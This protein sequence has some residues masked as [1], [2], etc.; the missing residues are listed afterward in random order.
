MGLLRPTGPFAS[1]A[2]W[3]LCLLAV[4]PA[5][6]AA[7]GPGFDERV[8]AQRAIEE[9]YWRHRSWPQANALPKP[10]P[11]ALV[12]EEALRT[13]VEDYLRKSSALERFW[14]RPL[15][16][17]RLQAELD[18]MSRSTRAPQVLRELYAALDD[19]ARLIAETLGRQTLVE[20]LI[21]QEYDRD[22]RLHG[23]I[24]KRARQALEGAR[25]ASEM[26]ILGGEYATTTYALRPAG[27]DPAGPDTAEVIALESAEWS[28]WSTQVAAWFGA[29]TLEAAPLGQPSALVEES[30]RFFAAALLSRSHGLA[31]VAT[32]TWAKRS[33]D[34]WWAEESAAV[35][36]ELP[37][38]P[39]PLVLAVPT[40]GDCLDDAWELR[41]YAP[42]PR[43][44]HTAIWT[45]VE[46]IVWGGSQG[47]PLNTGGR[48]DP[49]TDSWTPT[50]TG[51]HVPAPR[52]RHQ[53]VWTGT[54]MIVWGGSGDSNLNTGGRYDPLTDSWTTTSTGADVPTPRHSHTAVWSGSAMIVWG[55]SNNLSQLN[56]GGRYEPA[57]DTWTATST[58]TGVPAPRYLHSA[59]WSGTEMIVWGGYDNLLQMNTGGRYEPATNSWTP[60][61]TGANVPAP[62]YFH[63]AV[64]TGTHMIVWGGF[65]NSNLNTGGRYE[66]ATNS[67]TATST[68]ANVPAPRRDHTALWT[69]AE[70]IVWGGSGGASLNTGGRYVPATDGWTPTSLAAGLPSPRE[71]HTAVWTGTEMIV[72]GG[73]GS[74]YL[75]SGGRYAPTSDAWTA[76]ATGVNV[77]SARRYHSAVWTGAEM[78]VWG[79]FG[80]SYL[81]SGGSY[82]PATDAWTTTSTGPN[83]PAPRR[84]HT[85]VWSGT[86]MVVWGG[87]GGSNLNSG[88]RY[89]PATDAWTATSTG[90]NVPAPRYNHTAIW[91]GTEM[92]VWGGTNPSALNSGGR[93]APATDS[94]A[95]TS[96]G[97]NVPAPRLYHSAVWTGTE[98]IVW[99]GSGASLQNTGGR[100]APATNGWTATSTGANAPA[101]RYFH[102]AVWTGTNMIVWGGSGGGSSFFDS[103][104]RYAPLMDRWTATSTGANV[105]APRQ[106][107]TAVWSGMQMVVWGGEPLATEVGL[108]CAEGCA[109]PTTSYADADG[110]GFGDPAAA[111]VT[112]D[113]SVPAGHVLNADDC[114]D[115]NAATYPGAAEIKDGQDNQC[116]GDCANRQSA[117][118]YGVIDEIGG[119]TWWSGTFFC[120]PAQTGA[121]D[122][123]AVR[124]PEPGFA[125]DCH[126]FDATAENCIDDPASPG[127]GSAYFYL[128]RS[129]TP[130]PPGSWGQE[131]SGDERTGGCLP[132]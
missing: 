73:S 43:Y 33:F 31:T 110:D 90:A 13:K 62:R 91:S 111:V 24:E 21:R 22:D 116:A 48:Y 115:A 112:G 42:G 34:A 93:Y 92:I 113:C 85:A 125:D 129:A 52:H 17:E 61:S 28:A 127:V 55:G 57:T 10:A 119:S 86:E 63:T 49:A 23:Q 56:T 126:V 109:G 12:S 69:G 47:T 121:S 66:P 1:P 38:V 19:D 89:A 64:W 16:D 103:G 95:A 3:C 32:V 83:V 80:A 79:G 107:H 60:T 6:R 96:T 7:R 131:S 105:P 84:F 78:I 45:G 71:D 53:A 4:G 102:T 65:G 58:G 70:M 35:G 46:M 104:G 5:A 2:L 50:S 27:Q 76:T 117:C 94:W 20:R 14:Q 51:A 36:L 118:G 29:A 88:G 75:N 74:S 99:G 130:P 128:V 54:E 106:R 41:F 122:Y 40:G 123:Q 11:S 124:S 15:T 82:T 25:S 59:V 9:V 77:P 8:L 26:A 68:G 132:P 44:R 120:W 108:Y 18:R 98:M 81:N 67:W 30:D 72:W 100:Y 87:Y 37:A 101:P 114:D 97:A 39:G